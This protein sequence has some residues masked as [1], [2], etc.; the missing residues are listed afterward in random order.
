MKGLPKYYI[1]PPL[2]KALESLMKT[3]PLYEIGLD[4]GLSETS[5]RAF[6]KGA[7]L[8]KEN[9]EKVETFFKEREEL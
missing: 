4:I 7:S 6:L 2:K 1:S 5:L 9:Y 3:I 8:K